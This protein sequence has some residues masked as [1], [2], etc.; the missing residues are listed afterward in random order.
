M[1]LPY[2]KPLSKLQLQVLAQLEVLA[3]PMSGEAGSQARMHG[4]L[5]SALDLQ[6]NLVRSPAQT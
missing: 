4:M 5:K 2:A 1:Q 6:R 3:Q